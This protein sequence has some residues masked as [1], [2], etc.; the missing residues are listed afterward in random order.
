MCTGGDRNADHC[1]TD[2]C[3]RCFHAVNIDM[4]VAVLW[5]RCIEQ[6]IFIAGDLAFHKSITDPGQLQRG[7]R[8]YFIGALEHS[9]IKNCRSNGGVAFF[10]GLAGQLDLYSISGFNIGNTR[11]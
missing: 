2:Q 5:N 1:I 4:P 6:T 9:I 11:V 10:V 8:K 7:L 3:D